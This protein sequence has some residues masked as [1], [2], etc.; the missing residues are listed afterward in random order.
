MGRFGVDYAWG[1]P[2]VA[3]L[4]AA[5]VTFAAR[6]LSHDTTGKNLTH[7]EAASLSAGGLDVVVVWETGAQR[8]LDGYGAGVAD[9]RDADAQASACGMPSGRPIYFA[10]DFDST[11]GQQSAINSYLDGVASVI[12]R[13]R[14]GLYGGYYPVK[15]AF[16]A[17][18]I[19]YGWQT[20]AWSGGQWDPRAQLQQYSNDHD[21][22]GVGLD[23]D[24]STTSDFGQ[25]RIGA[26]S[27]GG[28]GGTG[29]DW[30][31]TLVRDLPTLQTGSTGE[32]VQTAQGL[33]QA[34]SHPEVS[35]DGSYG[36]V[37]ATAVRA[38]QTWGGVTVDGV[39]GPKT[40][41]VLL[42]INA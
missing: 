28:G 8:V 5:G 16:D 29:G 40:W 33:L 10:C 14:T 36:P 42:R 19:R 26:P 31:E 23:Y 27:G 3:A 24:R 18:K 13:G 22:N 20:Y 21:I 7:S 17:G 41:P 32:D 25:W 4:Q 38:V 35:I 39:V 11:P 15:R 34:R 6:Y 9:A 37:T 1:R 30:T 12:G 2:G